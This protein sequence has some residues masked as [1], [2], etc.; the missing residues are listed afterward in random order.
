MS[1]PTLVHSS[2]KSKSLTST[3]PLRENKV[4]GQFRGS[5]VHRRRTSKLP[6]SRFHRSLMYK[7]QVYKNFA[8]T[9][10]LE[11]ISR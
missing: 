6:Q 10:D 2:T 4:L 9:K 3:S 1:V 5:L 7:L 11:G 8:R